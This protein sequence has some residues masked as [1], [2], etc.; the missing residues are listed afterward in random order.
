MG[1]ESTVCLCF[2]AAKSWPQLTAAALTQ[3][4]LSDDNRII[5]SATSVVVK[6]NLYIG[7]LHTV[8]VIKMLQLWV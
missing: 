4:Q 1:G 3:G 2:G 8:K 7:T 5:N 6:F